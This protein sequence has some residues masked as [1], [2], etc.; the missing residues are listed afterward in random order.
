MKILTVHNTYQWAGGEDSVFESE[1]R[2]LSSHGHDV[3][4]VTQTNAHLRANSLPESLSLASKTVWSQSSYRKLA[5]AIKCYRPDVAHFHN[6]FP[7]I[8]PAA[9]YAC[10]NAGVPVVQTLH[11]YRLFCPK[12]SFF[13]KE[14]VCEQ[15]VDHGLARAI[16]Y[17]CYR[18]SRLATAAVASMLVV[19]RLL[20]T[21][22]HA[23]DR[24]VALSSFAQDK[25]IQAGLPASKLTVKPNF[26]D[27]EPCSGSHAGGYALFVGRLVEEKGIIT[28][29]Q[30]FAQTKDIPLRIV[31]DGPMRQNVER[32][33]H[34]HAP[35]NVSYAGSVDRYEIKRLMRAAHFLI[36]PSIWYEG[37]PLTIA[38]SYSCGTPIVASR[39]GAMQEIVHDGHTGLHFA[40]GDPIDLAQKTKWAWE[41]PRKMRQM[42]LA[43]RA[44]F[45]AKY[46]AEKNYE[47][48]I[49]IY[50]SVISD[51][52]QT[53]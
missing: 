50:K 24:Y 29:L 13:R 31:G 16:Y 4:E 14:S 53:I 8:S 28:L 33:I 43:A 52:K 15:C 27:S 39:L 34:Q 21:W 17:G 6:T 38:E 26:V 47:M 10:K 30:A 11:N 5:D 20:G 49:A 41:N 32:Y 9:Y 1:G 42:G 40:P 25:F 18:D 36:F 45:E 7:L 46:T 44:E 51:K 35:S 2:L 23:V 48:L 22:H 19:H 37:F 3:I 12:A